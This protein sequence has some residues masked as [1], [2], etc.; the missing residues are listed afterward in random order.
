ML[1]NTNPK[2]I[3]VLQHL[4]TLFYWVLFLFLFSYTRLRMR[5]HSFQATQNIYLRLSF[6]KVYIGFFGVIFVNITIN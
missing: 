4:L 5:L 3:F 6:T 1:S 2:T